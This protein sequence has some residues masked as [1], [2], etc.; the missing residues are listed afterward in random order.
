MQKNIFYIVIVIII[1][2]TA[3][4]IFVKK[5]N[6]KTYIYTEVYKNIE[7]NY[8]IN[9]KN[10]LTFN[11]NGGNIMF[12]CK[13]QLKNEFCPVDNIYKYQTEFSSFDSFA[14][15]I[16]ETLIPTLIKSNNEEITEDEF[17]ELLNKLNGHYN[18]K[19]LKINDFNVLYHKR[20]FY[21]YFEGVTEYY[22][23]LGNKK[24]IVIT[25]EAKT[26]DMQSLKKLQ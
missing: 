22:V 25:D 16:E 14:K 17:E 9:Y 24:Y 13:T 6:N 15:E 10:G 1:I 4:F 2:L 8:Q 19:K 12:K 11:E 26:I 7:D 5:T 21:G 18:F 23:W 3:V 20:D